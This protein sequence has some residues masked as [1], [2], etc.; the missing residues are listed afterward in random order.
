[1]AKSGTN[2]KGGN[3]DAGVGSIVSGQEL[4][5]ILGISRQYVTNH[6]KS[7]MPIHDRK[8]P[9]DSPRFDSALC[10]RWLRDREIQKARGGESDQLTIEEIRRRTELAKM[11]KEE[12]ELAVVEER[13]G[14]V[15][16]ILEELGSA[17]AV[18]RANLIALPK[19][20]AQLEH[21]DA[22]VIE[23]RLEEEVY[24]MLEELSDFLIEEDDDES[25]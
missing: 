11:K 12:I 14:D 13:Y 19:Y 20:A 5:R 1:M 9:R 22:M 25:E 16:A 21:Q 24:R 18:I 4:A 10:I 15:D 3:T 17:L 7:G 2:H 8:G 23:K 6:S